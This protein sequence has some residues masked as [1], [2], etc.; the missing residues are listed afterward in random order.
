MMFGQFSYLV[1]MLIFTLIPIGILWTKNFKFLRKN[2]R[3]VLITVFIGIIYQIIADPFAESWS[4][5]FFTKEKILNI[6]I[7]NCPIEN[8]I[9]MILI[10]IA[11]S[12]AVLTFIY[13]QETGKINKFLKRK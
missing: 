1:Y 6:W 3:I 12:S 8:L 5:W 9:F 4:A 11:I 2:G 13:Y 7:L 10:S